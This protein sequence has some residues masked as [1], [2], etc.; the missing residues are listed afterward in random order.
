VIYDRHPLSIYAV[1][2]KTIVD[3]EVR[4]DRALD[5]ERR[6][7]LEAEK[8]ELEKSLAGAAATG[9]DSSAPGVDRGR[10]PTTGAKP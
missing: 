8:S 10:K 3:G 7:A 1:V 9:A 4:F 6:P 2:Q 5:L